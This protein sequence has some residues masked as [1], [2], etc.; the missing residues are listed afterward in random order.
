[1]RLFNHKRGSFLLSQIKILK[2]LKLN[3][4]AGKFANDI[5]VILDQTLMNQYLQNRSA[6]FFSA[7]CIKA[8]TKVLNSDVSCSNSGYH[9]V[10]IENAI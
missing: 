7:L 8:A 4:Y 2:L 6:E 10:S 9:G 5:N 1:M 3:A